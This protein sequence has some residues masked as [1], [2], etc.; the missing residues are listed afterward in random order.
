MSDQPKNER[1]QVKMTPV[2]IRVIDDWLVENRVRGR[3]EAIRRLVRLGL[4]AA[5]QDLPM[6][7]RTG[8]VSLRE[9]GQGYI[10]PSVSLAEGL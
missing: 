4:Q 5:G 6:A 3:S 2:E 1:V 7:L 9:E 10:R 8:S